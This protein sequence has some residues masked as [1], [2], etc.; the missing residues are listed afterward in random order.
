MNNSIQEIKNDDRLLRRVP[1]NNWNIR[2]DMTATPMAFKLRK[3][4]GETGLSVNIERLTDYAKS[5]IDIILYRLFVLTAK[6]IREIG[7][8]CE[9]KPLPDN[10]A[11]AEIIG[12]ITNP[13]SSNLAKVAG[14]IKYP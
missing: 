8:D 9:H 13:V 14:Y 2:D 12:N 4:K 3:N 7:V 11:H 6:Q 1:Y 10:Y 5:I